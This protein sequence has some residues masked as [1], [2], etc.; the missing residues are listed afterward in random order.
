VLHGRGIP[1]LLFDRWTGY[2]ALA[3][4]TDG[5]VIETLEP[6]ITIRR[7][8]GQSPSADVVF[9]R[10]DGGG[11]TWPGA[12]GWIPPHL[13]R[14]TPTLDATRISW[15]FLAAHPKAG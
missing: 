10:I 7:W 1:P 14:T 15:E 11:H 13:G 9:Y 6:G 2:S 12:R 3:N 8:R 5:P 4:A